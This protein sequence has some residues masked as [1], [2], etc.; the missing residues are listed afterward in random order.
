MSDWKPVSFPFVLSQVSDEMTREIKQLLCLPHVLVNEWLERGHKHRSQVTQLA[1]TKLSSG[2]VPHNP[3]SQTAYADCPLRLQSSLYDVR[4]KNESLNPSVD[5]L[6]LAQGAHYFQD[7]L[8]TIQHFGNYVADLSI[9][10]QKIRQKQDE[11][12]RRLTELR[13]LL[14]NAP[15]LDKE[16][17]NTSGSSDRGTGYSLHQLQGDKQHGVTRTGHLLK[18]SEGKVRRV[19]QKRR[20]QVQAEG[21]LDICHADETKP[22]SKTVGSPPALRLSPVSWLLPLLYL[23]PEGGFGCKRLKVPWDKPKKRKE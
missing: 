10:L 21:F 6:N 20:C 4:V 3:T 16:A 14:R 23:W 22:P 13:T 5:G 11:E 15:G 9:K 1:S 8:K 7:G 18:K 12:K 17:M 19:W 2:I